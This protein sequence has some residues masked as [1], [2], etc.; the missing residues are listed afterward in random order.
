MKRCVCVSGTLCEIS[1]YALVC[2]CCCIPLDLRDLD[3]DH[4]L[5]DLKS[6]HKFRFSACRALRRVGKS[7]SREFRDLTLVLQHMNPASL[8]YRDLQYDILSLQRASSALANHILLRAG[9]W[10][11][12]HS[13]VIQLRDVGCP[14]RLKLFVVGTDIQLI[15]TMKSLL[16]VA[17]RIS[18]FHS[19]YT[20]TGQGSHCAERICES[21]PY[22]K[23]RLRQFFGVFPPS[24]SW[25]GACPRAVPLP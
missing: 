22:T 8:V 15:T 16:H 5:S 18:H 10:N 3:N 13:P 4:I 9:Q 14:Y 21:D 20:Y 1:L 17:L 2:S 7:P 24:P 12:W 25:P 19:W 6:G 11:S 23:R